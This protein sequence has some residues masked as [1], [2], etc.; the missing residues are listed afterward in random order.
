MYKSVIKKN[1]E[2]QIFKTAFTWCKSFFLVSG[3][4]VDLTTRL[5]DEA[6]F[7]WLEL[8]VTSDSSVNQQLYQTTYQTQ[9]QVSKAQ[10][11]RELTIVA[12]THMW[13]GSETITIV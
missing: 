5:V 12:A 2:L 4:F 11:A 9:C 10:V 7:N 8:K 1:I 3:N 13:G 6:A